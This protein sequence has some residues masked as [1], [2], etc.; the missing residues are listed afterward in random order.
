MSADEHDQEYDEKSPAGDA[1]SPAHDAS[2]ADD[3]FAVQMQAPA[4]TSQPPIAS[5]MEDMSG[6]NDA[7]FPTVPAACN[8]YLQTDSKYM[9]DPNPFSMLTSAHLPPMPQG[10]HNFNHPLSINNLMSQHEAAKLYPPLPPASHTDAAHMLK[11]ERDYYSHPDMT[12]A[13]YA[14]LHPSLPPTSLASLKEDANQST[15]SP[16]APGEQGEYY[17]MRSY[18]PQSTSGL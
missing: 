17:R 7:Q 16:V 10:P 2:A 13:Y 18:T 12:P 3:T 9:N 4:Y 8:P 14:P 11:H 1:D 5:R 6:L 15:S